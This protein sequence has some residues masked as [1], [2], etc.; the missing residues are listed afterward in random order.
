MGGQD[1]FVIVPYL[2]TSWPVTIR[3]IQFRSSDDLAGVPEDTQRHLST[4]FSMFFLQNDLRIKH[5]TYT[6]LQLGQ[7]PVAA[8]AQVDRLWEAQAIIGYLYTSPH[9]LFGDPSLTAEHAT[10]Y[11]FWPYRFFSSL[12]W[13]MDGDLVEYV[14]QQP[15]PQQ[16]D[17][18]GYMGYV[19]GNA[20]AP[21]WV[22]PGSRI[23]PPH[24]HL[25][26]NI[27]QNLALEIEE[28]RTRPYL[29]AVS[30]LLHSHEPLA[31]EIEGRVITAM[32]WYNRSALRG[33]T[34]QEAIL[35]LAIAFES[36]LSLDEGESLTSRFKETVKTLLGPVP[37]LDSWL[38]QFYEARS[39]TVHRGRPLHTVFYPLD[40]VDRR[41]LAQLAREEAG[42]GGGV[43]P[44]RSLL[45]DGRLIFR[46]CLNAVLSG[47]LQARRAGIEALL[48]TSEE[49]LVRIKTRLQQKAETP[50]ARIQAIAQDFRDLRTY[51]FAS[52]LHVRQE[53]A[54]AAGHALIRTYLDTQPS[55][56]TDIEQKMRELLTSGA[57]TPVQTLEEYGL[58]VTMIGSWQGDLS[59]LDATDPL[60]IVNSVLEFLSIHAL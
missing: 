15:I 49:R 40:H 54:V 27:P 26:L 45:A 59:K 57:R 31:P 7:D 3:G 9:P 39:K 44:A 11:V 51:W 4:L 35:D 47:A 42:E 20:N 29:W 37:R 55:L 21:L 1:Y 52:H 18:D 34:D 43:R 46:I 8:R 56:P 60:L 19:N 6:Y 28:V 41:R 16:G 5:L 32:E 33:V 58:L 23:Y 12:L 24:P 38:V 25:V 2:K 17:L 30:E 36:V 22:T 14:G 53:V 50:L 48:V 10:F 13:P